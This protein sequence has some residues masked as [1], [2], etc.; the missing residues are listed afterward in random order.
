V[1]YL[2]NQNI[3]KIQGGLSRLLTTKSAEGLFTGRTRFDLTIGGSYNIAG[4]S[5]IFLPNQDSFNGS[6]VFGN[7]GRLLTHVTGQDAQFNTIGGL[8]N[9][10]ALTTGHHNATFGY[11]NF[12]NATDAYNN[13]IFGTLGGAGITHAY[14]IAGI[15]TN[16]F[17]HTTTGYESAGAG[18]NVFYNSID[19]H[20]N[21]AMAPWGFY[22]NISG[23]GLS[24]DWL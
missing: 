2:I 22:S 20:Y 8:F 15:G 23:Y 21:A 5:T 7:G 10:M 9:A 13:A 14:D 16:A 1:A 12:L 3:T 19:A 24:G 6:V 4:I 11:D 17:F 18:S